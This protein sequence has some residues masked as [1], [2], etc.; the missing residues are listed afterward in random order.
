MSNKQNSIER[1]EVVLSEIGLTKAEL[2]RRVGISTRHYQQWRTRK[3]IPKPRLSEVARV[4]GVPAEWLGYA[5]ICGKSVA[6]R[7]LYA[8]Q[9]CRLSE[10]DFAKKVGLTP[11]KAHL[12]L[13]GAVKELDAEPL[14]RCA[15]VLG[16]TLRELLSQEVPP[17][18][19]D[20]NVS[21]VSL[22]RHAL[23][24]LLAS[25]PAGQWRAVGDVSVDE[26]TQW[27]TCPV[28]HSERTFALSV[29]GD[30]M[31]PTYQHGD[32]I[33]IDPDK[34][35]V[36]GA[37]VVVNNGD[38]ETTFKKWVEHNGYYQLEALNPNWPQKVIPL[39]PDAT[40]CGVVIFFG[41]KVS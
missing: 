41:R 26:S 13:C 19:F 10:A 7:V 23:V 33:F 17:S 15:E 37:L 9:Q 40:V 12:L 2:G 32:F 25:V 22:N 31:L 30:S 20:V 28:P 29:E 3:T 35:A 6:A 8:M 24:P 36:H 39:H 18:S 4:V 21:P 38:N 27:L 34:A 14:C 16:V 5:E 1:L 11:A